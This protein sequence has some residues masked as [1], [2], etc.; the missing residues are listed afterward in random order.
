MSRSSVNF[1]IKCFQDFTLYVN[2]QH[3]MQIGSGTRDMD[4]EHEVGDVEDHRLGEE[5]CLPVNI[6]WW[7]PNLEERDKKYSIML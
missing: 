2:T 6:S 3:G 5:L 1:V 4:V 7:I